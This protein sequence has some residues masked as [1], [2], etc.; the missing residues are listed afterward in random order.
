MCP[1]QL[2]SCNKAEFYQ[3]YPHSSDSPGASYSVHSSN[4]LFA[5]SAMEYSII[6]YN[7]PKRQ[8]PEKTV[9]RKNN[10]LKTTIRYRQ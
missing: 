10:S 2:H 1:T 6:E 3:K 4:F 5:E 7:S 9:P 8:F